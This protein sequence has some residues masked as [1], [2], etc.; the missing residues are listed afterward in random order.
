MYIDRQAIEE[1][2]YHGTFYEIV[3]TPPVDGDWFGEGSEEGTE[4]SASILLETVCD[5]QQ[6]SKLISSG[7]IMADYDVYFPCESGASLPIRMNSKFKCDDYSIPIN[8]R[9]VGIEGSQLG[10]CK[11]S[12]K[13]SEV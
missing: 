10:A 3:E 11:V 5:I 6:A 12:I 2:K 13:M 1:F 8:G 4:G 9:V 7:T